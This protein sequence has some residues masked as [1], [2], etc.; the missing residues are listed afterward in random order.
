L[1]SANNDSGS[2]REEKNNH[3]TIPGPGLKPISV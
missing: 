1:F 2:K 3:G